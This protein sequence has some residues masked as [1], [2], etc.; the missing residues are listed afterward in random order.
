MNYGSLHANSETILLFQIEA[1]LPVSET[2]ALWQPAPTSLF[3]SGGRFIQ[4][5]FEFRE[6]VKHKSRIMFKHGESYVDRFAFSDQNIALILAQ[7]LIRCTDVPL[8]VMRV[9]NIRVQNQV[10]KIFAPVGGAV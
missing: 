7:K 1:M 4:H 6:F 9:Q 10:G 3:R 5:H 2:T 8:R